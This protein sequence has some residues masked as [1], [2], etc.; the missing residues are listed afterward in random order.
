[1][2]FLI[3]PNAFKGTIAADKAASIMGGVIRE[4]WPDAEVEVCPIADGGDGTCQLLGRQLN[5]SVYHYQALNPIGRPVPGSL[6]LNNSQKTAYLDIST[7]SGIQWLKQHEVDAHVTSSYGTGELI[8]HAIKL[9]CEQ[10]VLGLGGSATVD[11]GTGILRALGYLF[12]DAKGREIPMFSPRFLSRIAHIQRPLKPLDV[13]FTCLCDVRNY[14]FGKE[15][16]VPVFGPQKGLKGEDLIAYEKETLRLFHLLQSRSNN[17]LEDRAGF[18][19]AGGIALGLSAFFPVKMEE[20]ARFFFNQVDMDT[21]VK[22]A[23][24][25]VTGEGRYDSQSAGGKGSYELLQLVRQHGKKAL[26]VTSG[27]E[28]QNSGFDEAVELKDLDF[29][30]DDLKAQAEKNLYEGLKSY[31]EKM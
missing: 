30:A 25:V 3:A 28:G 26:L 5:L 24:W 1:M 20:G 22:E 31:L 6:Y 2:K 29:K 16:A 7:V 23:D 13:K 8:R 4:R 11:M 15:G 17:S 21:K 10:I 19:A 12:L 14:F 18:G 9:G 27:K